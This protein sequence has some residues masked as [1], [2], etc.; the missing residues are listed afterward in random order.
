MQLDDAF[1]QS[2]M[3]AILR[4]LTPDEAID[5]VGLLIEVSFAIIEVPLNSPKPFESIQRLTKAYRNQAIIGAGT[6]LT[7]SEVDDLHSAG[8]RL[9]VSPNCNPSVIARAKERGMYAFPGVATPT[10]AFAA[11]DAGADGLK[12]FPFEMLGGK[13]LKAWKSVLPTGTL[14]VPVGGIC[15]KVMTDLVADGAAGFGIG[16]ALYKQGRTRRDIQDRALCFRQAELDAFAK[17][18]TPLRTPSDRKIKDNN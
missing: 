9:M 6:V 10:E 15:P 3:I 14:L 17:T 12:L 13:A 18:V 8:G 4:G 2:R 1:Q 5:I 11:L 16:S 7:E